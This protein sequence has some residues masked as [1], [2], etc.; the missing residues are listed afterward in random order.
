MTPNRRSARTQAKLKQATSDAVGSNKPLSMD[1]DD[2][3]V[4]VVD[5]GATGGSAHETGSSSNDRQN[6]VEHETGSS[7]NGRQE[8]AAQ[9]TG[10][11][12]NGRQDNAVHETGSSSNAND[13]PET[14][15]T[16][17]LEIIEKNR[18]V[19]ALQREVYEQKLA[20]AAVERDRLMY[21]IEILR[22]R[23]TLRNAQAQI[24][25]NTTTS[26]SNPTFS[27]AGLATSTV[28]SSTYNQAGLS[29]Y[30]SSF[31]GFSAISTPTT[32]A[33]PPSLGSAPLQPSVTMSQVP[34]S[35][36]T[37][38]NYSVEPTVPALATRYL[39]TGGDVTNSM[40]D[41]FLGAHAS[42]SFAPHVN[43]SPAIAVPLMATSSQ[44]NVAPVTSWN[45]TYGRINAAY[46]VSMNQQ[47][48]LEPRKSSTELQLAAT[49]GSQ[50]SGNE[51]CS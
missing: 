44:P 31:A 41:R 11:S 43:F 23:E 28:A 2:L 37:T 3:D 30:S 5:R 10:T 39:Q 9:E 1:D 14:I 8:N 21:E 46:G 4:T 15:R 33:V 50:T 22:L 47:P 25:L 45:E 32:T 12:S 35:T 34:V 17:P 24:P 26:I 49:S 42:T 19:L 20:T 16:N 51:T 38:P 27:S 48:R 36:S 13:D 18:R 29:G 40:P 6:N 7:S